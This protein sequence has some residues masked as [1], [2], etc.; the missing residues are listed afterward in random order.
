MIDVL[1][2]PYGIPRVFTSLLGGHYAVSKSVLLGLTR[3]RLPFKLNT[4]LRDIPLGSKVL[5]LAGTG[6]VPLLS[7]RLDLDVTIGPN[8]TDNYGKYRQFLSSKQV[9]TILVPSLWA[10]HQKDL[11]DPGFR[12][13]VHIWPVAVEIPRFFKV[14]T[15]TRRNNR[16]LIYIK[17]PDGEIAESV[18]GVLN[19]LGFNFSTV[20]YGAHSRATYLAHAA[21]STILIYLGS[22]ESQGLAL[23]EAWSLGVLT[24]V[25]KRDLRSTSIES[26]VESIHLADDLIAAPYLTASS[27]D[28]WHTI[29]ELESVLLRIR[30]KPVTPKMNEVLP[31]S[32]SESAERLWHI[33]QSPAN[34]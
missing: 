11:A 12:K 27:G 14:L 6:H 16:A 2:R 9:K 30:D 32:H 1:S 18:M 23:Q 25:L 4:R 22:W 31:K 7:T 20:K 5:L 21:R 28:F 34:V 3:S 8:F 17:Q 26:E 19:Q 29:Q 10:S 15:S 13:K 24:L 33:M